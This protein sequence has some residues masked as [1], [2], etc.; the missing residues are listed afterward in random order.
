MSPVQPVTMLS[1][2]RSALRLVARGAQPCPPPGRHSGSVPSSAFWSSPRTARS[3]PSG[4]PSWHPRLPCALH[5]RRRFVLPA[6]SATASRIEDS[7]NSSTWNLHTRRRSRC[8]LLLDVHFEM[9]TRGELGPRAAIFVEAESSAQPY[10]GCVNP[11]KGVA[12]S[13]PA[14]NNRSG[15]RVSPVQVLHA[16]KITRSVTPRHSVLCRQRFLPPLPRFQIRP[17]TAH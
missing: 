12:L 5:R 3:V 8:A 14:L 7:R 10:F 16:R 6:G 17:Q 2:A 4:V 11:P 1:P 15:S 13:S 9:Q